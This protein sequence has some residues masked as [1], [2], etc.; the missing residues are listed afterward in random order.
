MEVVPA[1]Y[2]KHSTELALRKFLRVVRSVKTSAL[3]DMKVSTSHQCATYLAWI[4]ERLA[5]DLSS[6]PKM[7]KITACYRCQLSRNRAHY[8]TRTKG[9]FA[10]H[11]NPNGL[12][13]LINNPQD[14]LSEDL[15]WN[16]TAINLLELN[17]NKLNGN[18]F[19]SNPSIYVKEISYKFLAERTNMIKDELIMKSMHRKRLE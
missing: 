18:S 7:V 6:H 12:Q 14:V 8:I 19:S 13:M 15:P 5:E 11:L 3:V 10:L 2:L 1:D 4:L 17:V 16:L 9:G